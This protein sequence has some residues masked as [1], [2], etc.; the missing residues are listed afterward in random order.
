MR[1]HSYFALLSVVFGGTVFAQTGVL[2]PLTP[3]DVSTAMVGL[4]TGQTARL[5]VL[6]LAS[7]TVTPAIPCTARLTF[8]DS[9]GRQLKLAAVSVVPGQ[10]Q[11]L[12][13]NHDTDL[14]GFPAHLEIRGMVSHIAPSSTGG[15]SCS[16]FA[17]LEILN[18]ATGAAQILTTDVRSGTLVAVPLIRAGEFAPEK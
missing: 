5:S 15:T 9:Q 2:A 13:L 7:P 14:T 16:L 10:A 17:S 18:N 12:D 1:S 3:P 8:F 4:V 11:S 6:N